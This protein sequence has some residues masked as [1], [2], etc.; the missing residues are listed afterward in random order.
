MRA[1]F[2]AAF[3]TWSKKPS[4][5]ATGAAKLASTRIHRLKLDLRNHSAASRNRSE[6]EPW[7][8]PERSQGNDCQ[9]N[10][11]E[12]TLFHS[13]DMHSP[14]CGF[15]TQNGQDKCAQPVTPGR[16]SLQKI[17]C[18]GESEGWRATRTPK[19]TAS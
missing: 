17:R 1:F 3:A 19:Q 16:I 4:R 14:D 8:R 12:N 5:M 2:A 11:P 15:F 18:W 10:K 13:L 7:K 9:G 6:D